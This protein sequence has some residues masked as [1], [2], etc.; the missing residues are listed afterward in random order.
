MALAFSNANALK[1][2][3]KIPYSMRKFTSARVILAQGGRSGFGMAIM[4]YARWLKATCF[5]NARSYT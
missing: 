4:E 5:I 2:Y 3:L 1:G